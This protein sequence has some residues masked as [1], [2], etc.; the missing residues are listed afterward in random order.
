MTLEAQGI[1]SGYKEIEILHGASIA[2][3]DAHI[4]ALL[5]P[6]GS[7]KST[8]LK[9]I[10]GFLKPRSGKILFDGEDITGLPPESM[11]SKGMAYVPQERT[12]FKYLTVLENLRLGGYLL[13]KDELGR[14]IERVYRIFP[15]LQDRGNQRA[16]SLSG[17]EQRMLE[18][19]RA[20]MMHPKLILLDEPSA[21]LSPKMVDAVFKEVQRLTRE[22][23]IS[24]IIVEQN[25]VKAIDVAENVYVLDMGRVALEGKKNEILDVPKMRALYLGS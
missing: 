6:N 24:F 17:G 18:I 25:V 22:E 19:A 2:V 21:N 20:L 16:S 4:V 7:G 9:T 14:A 12:V 8:L 3:G 5:G 11:L 13:S 1:I 15:F 10:F 23:R